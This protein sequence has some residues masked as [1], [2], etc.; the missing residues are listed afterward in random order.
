[1]KRVKYMSKFAKSFTTKEIEDLAV[2]SAKHN[3]ENDITG[4]LMASGDLF[5][6]IIEG[7]DDKIDQLV[8]RIVN[9]TRHK[10]VIILNNLS[11]DFS[12]LF[13]DW[14][15]RQIIL[16]EEVSIENNALKAIME[17]LF[18]QQRLT[19]NLT[20]M[21]ERSVWQQLAR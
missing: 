6:Q 14:S 8:E 3:K 20:Q 15:M 10:E 4:V 17:T 16:T 1:M 5:F 12:R 19:E 2:Q 9:D 13:P 18:I 7:P 21:L 11:G